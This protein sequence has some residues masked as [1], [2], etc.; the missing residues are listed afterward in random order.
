MRRGG[1][2]LEEESGQGEEV[3]EGGE[4]E[5]ARDK[6]RRSVGR[7]GG[8]RGAPTSRGGGGGIRA[9]GGNWSRGGR[10]SERLREGARVCHPPPS[11]R[12]IYP[13]P[14]AQR[15]LGRPNG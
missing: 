1:L 13:A 9:G 11:A 5:M 8:S 6:E 12:P 10:E 15:L 4:D 7:R 14:A 2:D 3:G